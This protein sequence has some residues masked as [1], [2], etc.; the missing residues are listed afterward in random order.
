MDDDLD[1]MRPGLVDDRTI[2]Q[3][4]L[5]SPP[6]ATQI[7]MKGISFAE[8]SRTAVRPSPSEATPLRTVIPVSSAIASARPR[9]WLFGP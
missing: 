2:R 9:T 6:I 7:L 8:T 1:A 3:L 5:A 4:L